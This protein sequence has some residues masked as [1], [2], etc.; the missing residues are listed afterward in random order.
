M[1]TLAEISTVGLGYKGHYAASVHGTEGRALPMKAAVIPQIWRPAWYWPAQDFPL[2]YVKVLGDAEPTDWEG[3]ADQIIAAEAAGFRSVLQIRDDNP[4]GRG[5]STAIAVTEDALDQLAVY[6]ARASILQYINE[7]EFNQTGLDPE[8][9]AQEVAELVAAVYWAVRQKVRFFALGGFA[10]W[11]ALPKWLGAQVAALHP[12]LRPRVALI[13]THHYNGRASLPLEHD[14]APLIRGINPCTPIG[15]TEGD[16][17]ATGNANEEALWDHRGAAF[18]VDHNLSLAMADIHCCDFTLQTSIPGANGN[19][20]FKYSGAAH[21]SGTAMLEIVAPFLQHEVLRVD[22]LSAWDSVSV[23]ANKRREFVITNFISDPDETAF[24]WLMMS[25][26]GVDNYHVKKPPV[27]AW[28]HGTGPQPSYAPKWEPDWDAVREAY[29]QAVAD[30]AAA[31]KSVQVELPIRQRRVEV[32]KTVQGVVDDAPSV[33][34][35]GD[36]LLANMPQNTV[37]Y[38][39]LS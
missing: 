11:Q 13:G 12:D 21:P 26:K 18:A 25:S 34:V 23:F 17:Y 36:V 39:R 5:E 27:L 20:F 28:L 4:T 19:G 35:S 16:L 3:V 1:T 24:K 8:T 30:Q 38:G 9:G 2:Y 33:S 37:I 15:M 31:S 6:S 7:P 22:R 14:Y 10:S 29:N 32:Y